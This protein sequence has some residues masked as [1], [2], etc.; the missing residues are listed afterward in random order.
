[1][2]LTTNIHITR[3]CM[4]THHISIRQSPYMTYPKKGQREAAM[5]DKKTGK[6][7]M[8]AYM[9]FAVPQDEGQDALLW[10]AVLKHKLEGATFI[11]QIIKLDTITVMQ[12]GIIYV[13]YISYIYN[14]MYMLA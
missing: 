9:Q 5:E 14:I 8:T 10:R 2:C 7:V 6:K 13:I 1:M 3:Y 12:V 4:A 11:T